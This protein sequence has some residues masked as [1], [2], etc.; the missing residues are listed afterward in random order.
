MH[1]L[2]E[3]ARQAPAGRLRP[4]LTARRLGGLGWLLLLL[5]F[6]ASATDYSFPGA[7]PAGCSGSGGVYTC[8]GLTLAYGD[9]VSILSPR[10]ATIRVNGAMTTDTVR[11]NS[12]GAA[13]D[14][15]LTVTGTLK[16]GYASTINANISAATVDAT[17]GSVVI[18]GNLASTTG[19]V[20]LGYVTQLTGSITSNTDVDTGQA[21]TI[22]GSITALSGQVSVRYGSKVSGNI[23][24]TT[25]NILLE[26]SSSVAGSL[27]ASSGAVEV[28]YGANVGGNVVTTTGAIKL[29]QTGVVQACVQSSASASISLSVQSSAGKVCCGSLGSCSSSCVA[30][31]SGAAMPANCSAILVARYDLEESAW[32]ATAGELKDTAGYTGG[33]FNGVAQGSALPTPT[34]TSPARS[35]S[36]GTCAYASL[37]GPASNGAGFRISGLPLSTATGAKTTVAFWMY[38]DGTDSVMPMGWI[39]NDLLLLKGSFG[40][41]SNSSNVY[42]I[43]SAG[44]SSGWHHVA[45]LFVNG[46]VASNKLY[47]DGVSQALSLR[48]SPSNSS[49]AAVA[50]TLYIS[51]YGDDTDNR[52]TG[53][54]DQFRV[55]NG[56][57]TA[58]E[59]AALYT[60][61]HA[62]AGASA[63]SLHHLEIRHASGSGLTCSPDTVTLMACQDAVCLQPY[64]TG[65]TGTLAASGAGM[66]VNWPDGAGFAIPA[67]SSS[68]TLRLQQTTVGS[69][70]LSISGS[71]P[72][73][74]S[75]TT[76]NFGSPACS[77]TAAD[78]GFLFDV[79]SH[80]SELA[81]TFNVSAVK[82]ANNSLA[83]V[84]A[85]AS[86]S[87]SLTFTC[88]Y[89]NPASGSVPLRLAGSAL[90][91][92]N[93]SA[94]ACDA[95]GR[96]VALAFNASGVASTTLL[97]ADVGQMLLSARYAGSSASS[98]EAG[99][100][101]T[102]S[103]SFTAAPASFGFSAVSAAPIR[104]GSAFAATLSARNSAGATTPNFG[105]ESPP[106][107]ATLSFVKRSPTGSGASGGVFSGSLGAFVSGSVTAANLVWSE[108]G[109]ADLGATLTSASYLG[110]GLSAA[111]S[112]GAAGAVGPFIPHHFDLAATPACSAVF[113][114]A[115]QPFAT[116]VTARNAAGSS[117]VNYD[118][119]TATTPNQAGAVTLSEASALGLGS[120]AGGSIAASA[121]NAGVAA[122][123]PGYS[124][125]S[126][127]TAPQTLTLRASNSLAG[128]ASVSS[129]GYAEASM[130]LR[131]G[132][133]RLSNAY[134]SANASLQL[135]LVAEYWSANSWVLNSVDNCSTLAA[136]NL[137]LSNPRSATGSS[138][139]ASSSAGATVLANGSSLI[140]LAAPTPAGSSLSLD[141]AIN[142]GS[143]SS[144]Q[145][146]Q[147]SHP[148]S[149]GAAKPWLRAQN[150]SC[151]ASADRDPS[152]RAS[153]GLY[154]PE[155][156][157]TVHARDIF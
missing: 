2:L 101:M 99:L 131:S 148:A 124:F 76:C 73:A 107:A 111:G 155:S 126:K 36:P 90:N 84:P 22:S 15:T 62:C 102:G 3:A 120:L 8:Y 119:S 132:R 58:A 117:T 72:S 128:N 109:S 51:G 82:K 85:F 49:S 5:P 141:L 69:S 45:A 48:K 91:S 87:K 53:S 24:T 105:R 108:V 100:V 139:T 106:E 147:T 31:S 44:L 16:L 122:A 116:T 26:Q 134:G 28:G 135:A 43:S 136:A 64:I 60:D 57:P 96:A 104:A 10:P 81:Q 86:T 68:G 94:T 42:G 145:S 83:C 92:S 152:A 33:P 125:A 79:P 29:D 11:I 35:G 40:F 30:N 110:S 37:A 144:D 95:G 52:F 59:V 71:T 61:T 9:T 32:S 54:L 20:T 121:F 127:T 133:L 113:S 38:W 66:T 118:G 14:L 129:A 112:T 17:A 123:S 140:T 63:N 88:S 67:G 25:Q 97:Y 130:P 143:S 19:A 142:L 156:R 149:V 4:G 114:Y 46:N 103:D 75:A 65:V 115:G 39:D 93:S 13:A 21:T 80:V 146:C 151:T 138:S 150:G 1:T 154:S 12:G 56:E 50:S 157:K 18:T 34:S 47:I 70:V 27:G 89:G 74:S 23:A 55:Y 153:F 77:W 6:T 137:V 7:L 98:S 41:N 78:A